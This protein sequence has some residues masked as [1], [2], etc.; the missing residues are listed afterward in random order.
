MRSL[1]LEKPIRK[2]GLDKS[3]T[4]ELNNNL[5]QLRIEETT[6]KYKVKIGNLLKEL[7]LSSEEMDRFGFLTKIEDILHFLSDKVREKIVNTDMDK[8][9]MHKVISKEK[10]TLSELEAELEKVR[11]KLKEKE[12]AEKELKHKVR[13]VQMESK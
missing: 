1:V 2:E 4:N 9:S 8:A 13:E 7:N 12:M 5:L 6:F 3:S 10:S 11:R